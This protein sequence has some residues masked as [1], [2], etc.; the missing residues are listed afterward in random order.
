MTLCEHDPITTIT[1][2]WEP[3]WSTK[4]ILLSKDTVDSARDYLVIRFAKE[5]AFKEYG[6]FVMKKDWV[7]KQ[8]VQPNGRGYVYCAPLNKREEFIGIKN[9]KHL[10]A[11]LL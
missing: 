1:K 11:S 8:K 6:W 2:V 5:S 9:C 4:E 10:Q 3:K 7:Q